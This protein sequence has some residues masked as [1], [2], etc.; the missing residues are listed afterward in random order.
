MG[1]SSNCKTKCNLKTF[2]NISYMEEVKEFLY[3]K[4]VFVPPLYTY[5]I[6][7]SIYCQYTVWC[8][9]LVLQNNSFKAISFVLDGLWWRLWTGFLGIHTVLFHLWCCRKYRGRWTLWRV[10][11]GFQVHTRS[12]CHSSVY[13]RQKKY[14]F[15]WCEFQ[16]IYFGLDLWFYEISARPW[17]K[18]NLF[19]AL[20]IILSLWGN[21]KPAIVQCN[22]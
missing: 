21:R 2:F 17:F 10:F 6:A 7:M 4:N 18:L 1:I 16:F 9:N 15:R 19:E 8:D 13:K 20:S 5:S 3:W 22:N 12:R 14:F 11:N